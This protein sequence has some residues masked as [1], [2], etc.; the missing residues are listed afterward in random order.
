MKGKKY[1]NLVLL[2]III[3]SILFSSNVN[4]T[5]LEEDIDLLDTNTSS[6]I[7][8]LDSKFIN[9]DGSMDKYIKKDSDTYALF[10]EKATLYSYVYYDIIYKVD[11][12]YTLITNVRGEQIYR[13][14][15]FYMTMLPLSKY[16]SPKG[17]DIDNIYAVKLNGVQGSTSSW[18]DL[19]KIHGLSKY[20]DEFQA[21]FH[22]YEKYIDDSIFKVS[23]TT[24]HIVISSSQIKNFDPMSLFYLYDKEE[25]EINLESN[26]INLTYDYD[27]TAEYLNDSYYFSFDVVDSNNN[28]N[29]SSL[30]IHVIDDSSPVLEEYMYYVPISYNLT[31]ENLLDIMIVKDDITRQENLRFEMD[32][33]DD[34]EEFINKLVNKVDCAYD[35]SIFDEANNRSSNTMSFS[36]IPDASPDIYIN[37]LSVSED[38]YN[39]WSEEDKKDNML[40]VI[41]YAYPT[42][43]S[44]RIIN[45][46]KSKINNNYL[47]NFSVVTDS[48]VTV[49][50]LT[51][52]SNLNN[53]SQT[54][55]SSDDNKGDNNTDSNNA[56]KTKDSKKDNRVLSIICSTIL[57][58]SLGAFV[59]ML[60]I[61]KV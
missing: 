41:K 47:V 37:K 35:I 60:F 56:I 53:S 10:M 14:G 28:K 5:S 38:V 4:A 52:L 18:F 17:Y 27:P 49:D 44:I 46:E 45:K 22:G 50:T 31:F 61:K 20:Y 2:F 36:F 25:G 1:L 43:K 40:D 30:N 16:Y 21:D 7:N 48:G 39:S 15:K 55:S 34:K 26:N 24:N 32:D 13:C 33:A 54:N 9:D 42:V 6:S 59:Y 23:D 12:E 58:V 19:R 57:V 29:S 51:V 11:S 8:I 3:I